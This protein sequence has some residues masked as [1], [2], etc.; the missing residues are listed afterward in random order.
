MNTGEIKM[1]KNVLI[2]A[3]VCLASMVISSAWTQTLDTQIGNGGPA[4]CR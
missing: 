3:A 2:V 1:K 4:A